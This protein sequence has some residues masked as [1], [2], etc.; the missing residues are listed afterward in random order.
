MCDNDQYQLYEAND[1][2]I[3]LFNFHLFNEFNDELTMMLCNLVRL[4]GTFIGFL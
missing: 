3:H 4:D 2:E 1:F